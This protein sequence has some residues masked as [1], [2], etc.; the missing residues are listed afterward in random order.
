MGAHA[1]RNARIGVL[2][3]CLALLLAA[4]PVGAQGRP[5]GSRLLG[6]V[7]QPGDSAAAWGPKCAGRLLV[8][9]YYA[10]CYADELKEPYWVGYGLHLQ[11]VGKAVGRV[12]SFQP[13]TTLP[14]SARA[15]PADYARMGLDIGHMAPANDFRFAADA[16]RSTFTL[17]NAAPQYGATNRGRWRSLEGEVS[18]LALRHGYVWIFT[19]PLFLDS[20]GSPTRP[21]RFIGADSVAVPTHFFKIVLCLHADRSPE[22]AAFLMPNSPTPLA[23]PTARYEVTVDS[24]E[25]LTKTDFFAELPDSLQQA[26]EAS[27]PAWPIP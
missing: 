6:L 1:V 25:R 21:A 26:L 3:G 5:R 18:S 16:E 14:E 8:K 17:S 2:A 24:L 13:D 22:M 15:L 23:G 4:Q 7:S 12:G 19:G 10:V 11:P 27:R 20:L 9:A